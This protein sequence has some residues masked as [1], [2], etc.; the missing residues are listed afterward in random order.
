MSEEKQGPLMAEDGAGRRLSDEAIDWLVRLGS[1]RATATDR[2]AF[3]RWRQSST[4]HEAAAVEAEVLLH[5]VGETRQADELRRQGTPLSAGSVR[6]HPVGR[7]VLFAGAAAASVAAVA[8][9]LPALGPLSG[10][11]ADHATAVGGRKRVALADSSVV[12]LNTATAVSVDYS[13]QERRLVLHDGE[14]LFEVAKDAARPFIVVAGDVEVRAVGTAF[15]V[16]LK[17]VFENVTVSEGTVEV[18]MGDRPSIRVVAGQQLDVS[19]S[20]G[21]KLRVV[22]VDAATAWQ[23]GKLIFNRRPLENVVAELE[24]YRT[25]RIVILGDRLKTLEVTGVFDL[26]DTDRILRTIEE[27]TKARVV[28]MPLFTII[29]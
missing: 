26:D 20:D 8:V 13:A 27:T 14:A 12:V 22:D 17:R 6:R 11:Y 3:Q 28:Q 1:G 19:E 23:R 25:G 5:A 21:F 2:L 10:L 9:A 7:R 24:R 16:R 15:V 18:K 4:A 29:R